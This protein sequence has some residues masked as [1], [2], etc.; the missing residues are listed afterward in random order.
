M[1]PGEIGPRA[2]PQAPRRESEMPILILSALADPEDRIR[3]LTAGSDDYLSKPFDPRE[4]LAAHPHDPQAQAAAGRA[5]AEEVRFGR[6]PLQPG[7]RRVAARRGAG[8]AVDRA[9]A[10]C[11]GSWPSAPG[12]RLARGELAQSGQ[13][14]ER[15]E[16][17]CPD[18]PAAPQDRGRSGRARLSPDGARRRVYFAHRLR[19]SE[20]NSE[21][22]R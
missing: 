12:M 2:D 13:R 3:G 10:T 16:R 7:P 8:A 11:C 19:S 6:L 20:V 9:S 4:L 14:G 1:M 22:G 21:I 15:Q 18:Q 5:V 17:R